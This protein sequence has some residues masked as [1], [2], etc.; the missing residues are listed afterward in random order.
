MGHFI[1]RRR[2]M[3]ESPRVITMESNPEVMR[4]C[5]EQG[6]SRHPNYMTRREC[7]LVDEVE[8]AFKNSDIKHFEEFAYFVNANRVTSFQNLNMD[9][10]L[11]IPKN[12]S[13]FS[14]SPFLGSTIKKVVLSEGITTDLGQYVFYYIKTSTIVL[15]STIER[16]PN[17]CNASLNYRLD[18]IVNGDSVKP[19][20]GQSY[21]SGNRM[22]L[23]YLYVKDELVDLYKEEPTWATFNKNNILPLSEY[24]EQ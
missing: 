22:N 5:H 20:K 19:N 8:T 14:Y 9:G 2:V 12:V 21:Y 18:V 17:V 7:A 6:W 24:V 10:A 1:R 16:V 13:Y 15:P 11:V 3:D 4:I 23:I